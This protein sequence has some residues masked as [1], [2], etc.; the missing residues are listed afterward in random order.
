M[1]IQGHLGNIREQLKEIRV[2]LLEKLALPESSDSSDSA[3][4][5][6]FSRNFRVKRDAVRSRIRQSDPFHPSE[7]T[8][9]DISAD[10]CGDIWFRGHCLQTMLPTEASSMLAKV[11]AGH[12]THAESEELPMSFVSYPGLHFLHKPLPI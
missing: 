6:N 7:H 5:L 10:A 12:G 4:M 8:Q 9:E 3:A 2:N 11:P 1:N